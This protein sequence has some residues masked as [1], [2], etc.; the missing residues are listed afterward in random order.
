M[1]DSELISVCNV[2]GKTAEGNAG[3]QRCETNSALPGERLGIIYSS[4]F[5]EGNPDRCKGR[6]YYWTNSHINR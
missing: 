5:P 4:S 6:Y 2:C 3:G 1:S